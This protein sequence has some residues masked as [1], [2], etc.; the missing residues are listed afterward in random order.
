VAPPSDAIVDTSSV[1]NVVP[2]SQARQ[3]ERDTL[4]ED[5][6]RGGGND[7]RSALVPTN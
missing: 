6:D 2:A 1:R 3:V 7:G 4:V 5:L